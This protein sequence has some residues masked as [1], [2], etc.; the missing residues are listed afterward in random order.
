M[1]RD[2]EFID[3]LIGLSTSD[4]D[5][6]R[7]LREVVHALE[8]L[9]LGCD[10]PVIIGALQVVLAKEICRTHAD[11]EL[12]LGASSLSHLFVNFAVFRWF[13]DEIRR[14]LAKEA[15]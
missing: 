12:A 11:A 1:T 10:D 8:Q 5:E 14:D 9:V 3:R 6:S 13:A 4:E 7:K 2:G 15:E